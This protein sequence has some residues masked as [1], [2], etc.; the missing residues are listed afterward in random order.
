MNKLIPGLVFLLIGIFFSFS[1]KAEP[2]PL[3]LSPRAGQT[4]KPSSVAQGKAKELY[5]YTRKA[6]PR[7]KWNQCLADKAYRRARI[8]VRQDYFSHKDPQ[9]GENP[10]WD[11]VMKCLR[12]RVAGENLARG[13]E[14]AR[15]IH[16]AWMKSPT[17]R[18]NIEDPRFTLVGI[19]C[20]EHICVQLFAGT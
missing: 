1:L 2:R 9:T 14:P 20:Y 11:L 6:N 16:E 5:G 17:H 19:G 4:Q 8:M 3:P 10:A 18:K 13:N 7:L 12:C 15:D